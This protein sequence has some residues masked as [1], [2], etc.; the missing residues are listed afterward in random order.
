MKTI[1]PYWKVRILWAFLVALLAFLLFACN[2]ARQIEKAEQNVISHPQSLRKVGLVWLSFNPCA[3]DSVVTYLPGRIDS[4][5]ID[6]IVKVPVMDT[7]NNSAIVDS[8]RDVY[9]DDCNRA[10]NA[11]FDL[12]METAGK[13][14]AKIKIP[15][16]RP[17]TAKYMIL[18]KQ[19]W[20]L[21]DDSLQRAERRIAGLE[22]KCV[23]QREITNDYKHSSDRWLRY[24]LIICIVCVSTNAIWIYSKFKI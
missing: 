1:N 4:I 3:N 21:L 20:K 14:F 13:E 11:A 24:F 17:D 16:K 22:Q 18:D 5:L 23:S 9:A 10:I 12:G 6:K 7:N 8:L 19:A 15:V 2:P